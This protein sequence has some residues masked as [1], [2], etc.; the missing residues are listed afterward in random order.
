MQ[1]STVDLQAHCCCLKLNT[2]LAVL[3]KL[4]DLQ[5]QTWPLHA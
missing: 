1:D 3:V 2:C 5:T 4:Q